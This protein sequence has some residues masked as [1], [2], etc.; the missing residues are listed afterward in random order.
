[1]SPSGPMR[2]GVALA[3]LAALLFGM[4][5]PL[6]KRASAGIGPL[7]AGALPYLG[8]AGGAALMA[9]VRRRRRGPRL[10]T[11]AALL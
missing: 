2:R 9:M 10:A 1:M 5:A 7:L 11:R 6:L 8:A 3:G 4:T